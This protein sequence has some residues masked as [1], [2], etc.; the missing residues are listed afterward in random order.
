[1]NEIHADGDPAP[2]HRLFSGFS[3]FEK[4]EKAIQPEW[5]MLDRVMGIIEHGLRFASNAID[6]RAAFANEVAALCCLIRAYQG[7][8]SGAQL[9]ATGFYTDARAVIRGAYE[10]GGL[11]RMLAHDVPLAE[12][13]LRKAEWVPDRASRDFAV[14]LSGGDEE[15]KIPYQQYY[16]HASAYAHPSAKSS[17]PFLFTPDAEFRPR[18]YP[19]FDEDEL[20]AVVYELTAEAIFVAYCFR[21]AM[22]N[23]EIMDPRWHQDLADVA[24]AFTGGPME[25]LEADWEAKQRN[26]E[27]FQTFVRPAE[28]IDEFLRGHPNAVNNV[29]ARARNE[30]QDVAP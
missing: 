24:R 18:P 11:S 22:A 21:N 19:V 9:A 17:L 3:V 28:E 29:I 6:L 7:L 4:S 13:W 12:R 15:A 10:S 8:Q 30:D 27:D 26:Y 16:K 5:Q 2:L 23:D 1:M 25:H 20:R 14:A